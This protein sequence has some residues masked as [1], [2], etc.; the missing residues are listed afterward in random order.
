MWNR[1]SG[2]AAFVGGAAWLAGSKWLPEFVR[3]VI[4]EPVLQIIGPFLGT[5][6]P[7]AA[8]A[9]LGLFLFW[10]SGGKSW[11]LRPTDAI[12]QFAPMHEIVAHVAARIG[13]G[14]T[15]KFWPGAR[16]A[17]RQAAL[18]GSVQIYGHKS[19]DT[20]SSSGTSWSLV[21]SPIPRAY[22]E[23]ADITPSATMPA[24]DD[25]LRHHT[26][27]HRL[28]DGRF[29]QK[30]IVFY[31]KLSARWPELKSRWP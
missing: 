10:L 9:A 21:R 22:W 29:T 12:A 27:P 11:H 19:E 31:A 30:E 17:I 14:D 20:G 15:S 3:A 26:F 24:H 1:I 23:L 28:S 13:D 2:L 5:Y 4:Y 16:H 8:L 6:A 7:G 25:E 18:D